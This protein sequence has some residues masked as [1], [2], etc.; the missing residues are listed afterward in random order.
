MARKIFGKPFLIERGVT[1]GDLVSLTIFNILVDVVVRAVLLEVCGPH[2]SHH[3]FLLASGEKNIVFYADS[4][5]IA[6]RN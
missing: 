4:G 3:E 6:G 5:W 1:Q 2:G